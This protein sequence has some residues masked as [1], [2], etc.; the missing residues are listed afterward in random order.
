MIDSSDLDLRKFVAPEC[1]FG[2]GARLLSAKYAV[3][4]GARKVMVVTDP[5]IIEAGWTADILDCL[6]SANLP[7]IVYDNV[8]PNPTAEQVMLGA[9]LYLK[10]KCNCIITVGGGSAID[11]AKGIGIVSTNKRHILEFEGVDEVRIPIPPLICIPTTGGSSAEVSQFAI[12]S[13]TLRKIKIAII[14]KAIVPDV[15][16][17]D[18]LTLTTMPPDLTAN[19]GLDSLTHAFEAYVSNAHSSLTDLLALESVKLVHTYLPESMK[20]PKNVEIRGKI[21]SACMNVGMAFSNAGLGVVHAMAHS[22]GGLL[23]TAHGQA[24]AILLKHVVSYNFPVAGERYRTLGKAMGLDLDGL[25]LSQV[26][27]VITDE[28]TSMQLSLGIYTKLSEIGVKRSD[29]SELAGRALDD[30]DVATNPKEPTLKDIEDIYA[31][32]L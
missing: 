17:I 11:C 6:K 8:T 23:H 16:L 19:T 1:V 30:P 10:E 2:E 22:L 18:P 24:N 31:A 14:S 32:A 5:G 9:D 26:E 25:S 27:K 29:I 12:I 15:A 21:A 28:L 7:F 4:L 13:D 3:N 20:D